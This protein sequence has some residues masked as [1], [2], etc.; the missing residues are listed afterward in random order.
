MRRRLSLLSIFVY[1]LCCLPLYICAAPK[2]IVT[3]KDKLILQEKLERFSTKVNLST[4][5]LMLAIGVDFEGTPYVAQ[6]LDLNTDENL[7]VNLRELDCTTFVENCLAIA[8]TV[9]SRKPSYDTF[10]AELE[11]IRYRNGH[12]NG[13]VSRLHYFSEWIA[14]NEKR[15]IV[16]DVTSRLGGLKFPLLLTFMSTHPDSYPQL[17]NSPTLINKMKLIE[18]EVSNHHFYAIPKEQVPDHE[19]EMV[20][21]DII[22]LTTKIA[23]LDVTHLGLVCKIQ[24]EIFLLNGSSRGGKVETTPV[25]LRD[26]LM[27]SKITTGIFVVRAN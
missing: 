22:A 18:K 2:V 15:G 4:G 20:D 27:K 6:T 26:Y 11:K 8:L 25:P 21:G 9:K 7:V 5:A 10:I 1:L 3:E 12:L 16:T 13:Y 17:K 19:R 14:D 24:G 23:G